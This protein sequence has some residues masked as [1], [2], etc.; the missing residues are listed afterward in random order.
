MESMIDPAV[1]ARVKDLPLLARS[2]AEGFLYGQQQSILRGTGMEFSQY[3]SYEPGD[4]LGRIDWKLFARSDRY[5]VREAEKESETNVFLL[6][7]TTGSMSLQSHNGPW[8]KLDYGKALVAT[9]AYLAERQGDNVALL[10]LAQGAEDFL[11]PSKG[12]RH[13]H[14]LLAQLAGFKS[15]GGFADIKWLNSFIASLSKPSLVIVVSDFYQRNDE[16]MTFIKAINVGRGELATIALECDD[17]LDFPY[18]GPI[19]FKD[20]E[21]GEELLAPA[22]QVKDHYLQALLHYRAELKA[23]LL[24]LGVAHYPMNIDKP[25]DMALF[26]YLSHRQALGV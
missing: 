20:L 8:N 13:F 11:A 14:R 1:L 10:N 16:L 9:L 7:D 21:S 18:Q 24:G 25:M 2:V 23:D 12:Q 17:E 15:A 6:L 26:H 22:K 5:Y 3:R 4:E 19:R